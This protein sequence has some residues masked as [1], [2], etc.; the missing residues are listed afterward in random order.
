MKAKMG[1]LFAVAL[2]LTLLPASALAHPPDAPMV[3]DLIAGGGNV[4]SA[5]DVGD[6]LISN[7]V[8]YLYV[9]YLI[10]DGDW[11]LTETHLHVFLDDGKFT[12]IPVTRWGNPLPGRFE[13][14]DYHDCVDGFTYT[15][16]LTWDPGIEVKIAAHGVVQTIVG[17]ESGLEELEAMLPETANVHIVNHP[18]SGGDGYFDITIS[19]GGMLDGDHVAWCA[20]RDRGAGPGLSYPVN[21]YSS[22][23]DLPLTRP[24]DP[25]EWVVEYPDNLDLVNWILNQGFIGQPSGCDGNYDWNDVQLA[26]WELVEDENDELTCGA[27]EIVAAARA[28]GEGFV[29][30]CGEVV[31]V[32]LDGSPEYRQHLLIPVPVPCIPIYADETIWGAKTTYENGRLIGIDFPFNPDARRNWA[33]YVKYT[34]Q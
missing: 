19:E 30:G 1:I 8:D 12:D 20:D 27:G 2:M 10:T 9:E 26:I 5:M 15:I 16:P 18:A 33:T 28:N 24:W 31:G 4:K 25:L 17:Y 7:D 11:C 13:Y 6:L 23:E 14:G 22:Y 34:V 21:V 32:L 3:R 29:P